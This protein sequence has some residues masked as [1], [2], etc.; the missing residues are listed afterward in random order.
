M[1][2]IPA[3]ERII[4]DE[5]VF[6]AFDLNYP[7][8]EEVKAALH[9]QD[10]EKAKRELVRYFETRSNVRYY[11]DYRQL[12]LKP[13]ETDSNPYLFQ[14]SMGLKGSLKEFILFAGEKLMQHIY[15][16]PGRERT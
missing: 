2:T 12:P 9:S 1:R 5:E 8:L 13:V 3:D 4:T 7:G 11:Y 10:M 6:S 15:V 16:R 14:S